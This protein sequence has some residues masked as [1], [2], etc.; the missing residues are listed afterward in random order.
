MDGKLSVQ[1]DCFPSKA[2]R[3]SRISGARGAAPCTERSDAKQPKLPSSGLSASQ[4][5]RIQGLPCIEVRPCYQGI[6][7]CYSLPALFVLNQDSMAFFSDV[8]FIF[9]NATKQK[10]ISSNTKIAYK[11][12]HTI[13][14]AYIIPATSAPQRT[15]S[16]HPNQLNITA[17]ATHT[18]LGITNAAT[19]P[20]PIASAPSVNTT[21]LVK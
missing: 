18:I 21:P 16:A 11:N 3:D 4:S 15:L 14:T 10:I 8:F 6:Y 9:A 2:G 5:A 1:T 12:M 20:A 7:S 17:I 19:S 13:E